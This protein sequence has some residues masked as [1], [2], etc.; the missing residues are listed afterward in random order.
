VL[1]VC[2][3]VLIL[4]LVFI[5]CCCYVVICDAYRIRVDSGVNGTL[6]QAELFNADVLRMEGIHPRARGIIFLDPTHKTPL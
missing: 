1:V 2:A 6:G 5:V 4:L 3:V